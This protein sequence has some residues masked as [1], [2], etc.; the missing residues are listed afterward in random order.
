V[1]EDQN[2]SENNRVFREQCKSSK[3]SVVA[4]LSIKGNRVDYIR[5]TLTHWQRRSSSYQRVTAVNCGDGARPA[6]DTADSGASTST[7]TSFEELSPFPMITFPS[8]SSIRKRK[9]RRQE[10]DS[11]VVTSADVQE[12][13]RESIQKNGRHT[14]SVQKRKT[15]GRHSE[16]R[17]GM[18]GPSCSTSI[19]SD[20]NYCGV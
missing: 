14:R 10:Q 3:R 11:A 19:N 20:E 4:I 15:T 12:T 18:D 2:Y 16:R 6:D 8:D 13:L 17:I 1:T 7:A 9:E 5:I